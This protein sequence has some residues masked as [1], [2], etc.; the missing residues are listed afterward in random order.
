MT[1]NASPALSNRE[2]QRIQALLGETFKVIEFADST[3]T[4]AEAAAAV[5]CELRHIAKSLVFATRKTGR[6]VLVVASGANRVDTKAIADIA[7]ERVRAADADYIATRTGF[8]PGGV[9][10][11]GFKAPPD[12]VIL[13]ADLQPLPTVWAAA[14]SSNAV[15][16]LTP[17]QLAALTGGRFMEV[18]KR[19]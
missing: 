6:C 8:M 13:D 5:G 16:E 10:P 14:G 1:V 17:Q 9:S 15:F 12:L 3:H 4:S 7:G 2:A 18:A 11:V 19:D